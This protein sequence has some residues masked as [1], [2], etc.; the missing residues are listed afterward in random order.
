M[1]PGRRTAMLRRCIMCH[2]CNKYEYVP[3]ASCR[4]ATAPTTCGGRRGRPAL[5][6]TAPCLPKITAPAMVAQLSALLIDVSRHGASKKPNRAAQQ[7]LYATAPACAT[8]SKSSSAVYGPPCTLLS[9]PSLHTD[10]RRRNP[11]TPQHKL[12]ILA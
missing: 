11:C 9:P 12:S 7:P 3:L 1:L 4:P 2:A 5:A 10:Q 6:H 8:C